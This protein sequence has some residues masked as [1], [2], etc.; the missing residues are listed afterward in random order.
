M[1]RIEDEDANIESAVETCS[2]E[3]VRISK[4]IHLYATF[5]KLPS[6]PCSLTILYL[7]KGPLC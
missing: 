6:G 3:K 1:R 4:N 2:D 7:I 5:L